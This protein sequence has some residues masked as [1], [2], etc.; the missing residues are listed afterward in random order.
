MGKLVTYTATVG[1]NERLQ[2][3][4]CRKP[5]GS[6]CNLV[7]DGYLERWTLCE[8]LHESGSCDSVASALMKGASVC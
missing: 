4:F 2:L 5:L 7:C 6:C 8:T 3:L 1:S